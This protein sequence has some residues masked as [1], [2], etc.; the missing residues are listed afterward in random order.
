MEKKFFRLTSKGHSLWV[1][2]TDLPLAPEYR[3]I[4]GLVEYSGHRDVIRSYLGRYPRK[5]VDEWLTEFEAMRLIESIAAKEV[6]LADLSR[7]TAPPPLEPEDMGASGQEIS[8]ADIS[9]S[10][11]GVYVN[12]ERVAHHP[13]SNKRVANTLALVVEDDPDQSALA[14]LRLTSAGYAVETAE[15]VQAFFAALKKFAPDALFLDVG[16]PDGDG[17]DLLASLRNHPAYSLMPIVMLTAQRA[18]EDIARGLALGADGYITKPYGR[19]TLDYVL[20]YVMK[21]EVFQ[22]ASKGPLAA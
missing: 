16:L 22:Q 13:P 17:F 4:L 3:R 20:R 9:L 7:K 15:S 21:Q 6:S 10:Q 2:R 14:V 5:L 1:R 12:H 18:P 19:N 11:L 8:F